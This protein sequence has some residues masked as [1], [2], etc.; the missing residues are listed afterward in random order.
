M[1]IKQGLK[2]IN[3][4]RGVNPDIRMK[5]MKGFLDY[6]IIEEVRRRRWKRGCSLSRQRCRRKRVLRR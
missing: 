6:G 1:I 3:I 4:E 5:R 2:S